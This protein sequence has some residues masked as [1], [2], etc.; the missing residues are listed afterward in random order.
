MPIPKNKIRRTLVDG[1]SKSPELLE[2]KLQ[3]VFGVLANDAA[4]AVHNN[5]IEDIVIMVSGGQDELVEK[6]AQVILNVSK[7]EFLKEKK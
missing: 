4:V 1:Y 5:S 7:A 2:F 3:Q 6:V